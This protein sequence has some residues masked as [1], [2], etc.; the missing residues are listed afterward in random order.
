MP[1]SNSS[2]GNMPQAGG[3]ATP[4][5][6]DEFARAMSALTRACLKNVQQARTLSVCGVLDWDSKPDRRVFETGMKLAMTGM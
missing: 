5:R 4:V 6:S 2:I 3:N 1:N